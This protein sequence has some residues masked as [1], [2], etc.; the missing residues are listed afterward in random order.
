MKPEWKEF[1]TRHGAEFYPDRTYEVES[2]G[3]PER[4]NRVTITG[5]II[6]DLSHRGLIQAYGDDARSFLQG[7][8]TNNLDEVTETQGQLSAYCTP[9]GRV[10]ATFI[11][12]QRDNTFYLSTPRDVIEETLDRLRKYVMMS[13]ATLEDGN[14]S[15]VRLG[16]SG[17]E[18]ETELEKALG[19]YPAE[20]YQVKT[21]KQVSIMRLPG[22]LPRFMLFGELNEMKNLWSSL[23]VRCAP[24]GAANWR[25]LDVLAGL[26]NIYHGNTESVT[27]QMINLDALEGVSF[28]KG[29]YPGQEVVA[30][31]KYLG[32]V[33]RRMLILRFPTREDVLPGT[34]LYTGGNE[35]S[36]GTMISAARHPDGGIAA[37]AVLPLE[38]LEEDSAIRLGSQ[39]GP[40]AESIA[41][42]PYAFP[43]DKKA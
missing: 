30:R 38:M 23:N 42:P 18:A 40:A 24:V 3:N 41:P 31:V 15:L 19:G 36:I 27:P 6:C 25:L 14:D 43:A 17:P 8:T 9:K 4:E 32:K 37:L 21:L 26:P 12:L 5:N 39:D 7:Q 16:I 2:Y 28:S 22:A 1:L 35:Q 20:N 34:K 29:C 33:K 13:K 11:I 10:L